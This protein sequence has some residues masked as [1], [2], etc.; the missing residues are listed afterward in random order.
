MR[1]TVLLLYN[2][3]A[4]ERQVPKKLDEIIALHQSYGLLLKPFRLD[5]SLP[6]AE[7]LRG[8]PNL[9]HILIAGGDGTINQVVNTLRQQEL[10]IPVGLL[11]LGTANDFAHAVGMPGDIMTACRRVLDGPEI[12]V[13]LGRANGQIFVNV[14][15]F[16]V[17]ADI[18][19]VTDPD[20][21]NA[22]G[23]IAYY[24]KGIEQLSRFRSFQA[25]V[26]APSVSFHE[27][28]YLMLIFN[29]RSAGKVELATQSRIDDGLL[30]VLVFRA[31]N[32]NEIINVFWSVMQRSHLDNRHDVIYFKAPRLDVSVSTGIGTDMDGEPGPALPLHVEC[33]PKALRIRGAKLTEN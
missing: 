25:N 32:I 19:Q 28:I 29:G 16:G 26:V 8:T 2:P 15:S 4:G 14:L 33:L 27:K 23:R 21:K 1:Q 7:V 17:F 6:L 20:L 24:L 30:D 31:G 5:R 11:P 13:D 18:S 22:L 10:D 12:A 9:S 3:A